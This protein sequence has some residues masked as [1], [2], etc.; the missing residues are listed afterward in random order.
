MDEVEEEDDPE[1]QLSALL[2]GGADEDVSPNMPTIQRLLREL[3]NLWFCDS[4]EQSNILRWLWDSRRFALTQETFTWERFDAELARQTHRVARLQQYYDRHHMD[5][6][7][8][9]EDIN[10]LHR[11]LFGC[12]D[13]V[14]HTMRCHYYLSSRGRSMERKANL[15]MDWSNTQMLEQN[16]YN[17][18]SDD[19]T[20]LQ[21]LF[22]YLVRILEGTRWRR[23]DKAFFERVWTVSNEETMAFA[24]VQTCEEFVTHHTSAQAN[25]IAFKWSSNPHANTRNVVEMLESRKYPGMVD[26]D[27]NHHLRSYE[28]D[29]WKR[30][31]GV[32]DHAADMFF[33][34]DLKDDWENL[35]QY[36][37]NVRRQF[38]PSYQCKAPSWNDVCIKHLSCVFPYNI[39]TELVDM[40]KR[41][42]PHLVWR[43]AAPYEC[44]DM[45]DEVRCA[46]LGRALLHKF[47]DGERRLP[48][49]WGRT[50]TKVVSKPN[51]RLVQSVPH[52][53][54]SELAKNRCTY[55]DPFT[56]SELQ[57]FERGMGFQFDAESYVTINNDDGSTF[58]VPLL[59]PGMFERAVF[60][61][62]EWNSFGVEQR[63]GIRS[64]VRFEDETGETHFFKMDSGRTWRECDT[65]EIDTIYDC[66]KF[67]DHD[68]FFLFA[69]KG[70][71]FF[72]MG[73]RD[74]FQFCVGE[75]GIAGCGKSTL[76]NM[77]KMFWQSYHMGNLS[78]NAEK[79]FGAVNVVLN[80]SGK[81][82]LVI[83]CAECVANMQLSQEEWQ[84]M[85]SGEEQQV[86]KKHMNA[87]TV[88]TIAPM[89]MSGNSA[90]T[91]WNNKQGQVARRIL[92]TDMQFPVRPRVG[93]IAVRLESNLG[94]AQRKFTLAYEQFCLQQGTVD[95]LSQPERLPPAFLAFQHN[96]RQKCDPMEHFLSLGTYVKVERGKS[97]LMTEFKDL[98]NNYKLDYDQNK[99]LRW[100]AE[101]YAF[102]FSERMLTV[103]ERQA[104]WYDSLGEE[105]RNV[106]VI[107][108]ICAA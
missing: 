63:I 28:G 27:E 97:M 9:E 51:G 58:W 92:G 53:L 20:C 80:K 31:C 14:A 39:V 81:N 99:Q 35:A 59:V 77:L 91:Q 17:N 105:H 62:A 96:F 68:K 106:T 93:D 6:G 69:G 36:A 3:K 72:K 19:N 61:P 8:F 57:D 83:F 76:I 45:L 78:P 82:N 41:G 101:L 25:W 24:L 102:A 37:S 44:C 15:P 7:E 67:T 52:Q 74:Q 50:W 13:F 46:P 60:S 84:Q 43:I 32:Y 85:I 89:A 18:Q 70:R 87:F 66:Q 75:F 2:P 49:V 103:I 90:P 108:G 12:R 71:L 48:D 73:E 33:P 16:Y 26:I 107:E 1:W 5:D 98:F 42:Q 11:L 34:Y 64:F 21:N 79:I 30:G 40:E 55:S 10:K 56:F 95:P 38:N 86:A 29:K 4:V 100:S 104:V 47:P 65:P 54:Q 22:V 88:Q 23:A 94:A